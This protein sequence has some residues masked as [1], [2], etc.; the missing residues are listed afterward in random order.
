[1][2]QVMAA[3]R[4]F[5]LPPFLDCAQYGHNLIGESR[6][7]CALTL[8]DIFSCDY[9]NDCLDKTRIS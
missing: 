6:V 7:F 3:G 8:C 2:I 9:G 5:S 1:M 4:N